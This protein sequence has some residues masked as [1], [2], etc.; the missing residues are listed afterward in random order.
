MRLRLLS[1]STIL[2]FMEAKRSL[3]QRL[4]AGEAVICAEGYLFELEKRGWLQAGPFV[5]TVVL[6]APEK[7]LELHR[8]FVHAGSDV[9]EA[10][11]YYAHRDKLRV[12]EREAD[13]ER[14]NLEALSLAKV[15]A[16]ETNTLLAGNICNSNIYT[17]EAEQLNLIREMVTEQ[18]QWALDAGV[19]F[20]VGETYNCYQEALV[21][22]QV[23]KEA[24]L[25][26]VITLAINSSGQ[27]IDGFAPDDACQ[28]LAEA[29]AD[30][31]GLN[32]L[33]GP[34]TM[35]PLLAEIKE[36]CPQTHLAA[37]PV[38]YRTTA[39]QPTFQSLTDPGNPK[40]QQRV[41]P[42]E[43]DPLYCARS[44]I[45]QFGADA[46]RMGYRYLGVCCG[47][48]ADHIRA[49]ATGIGREVPASTYQPDLSKHSYLGDVNPKNK[50]Y[51]ADM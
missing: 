48:R 46:Y 17:G 35:L 31:V 19:D 18:A 5:P 34:G 37:L 14:L 50:Q 13:I 23:I 47:A 3:L 45:T 38:P 29:G 8:E 28:R 26:A 51:V 22:L 33:R 16:E 11:T 15:V 43:L 1:R 49:L 30:V 32:C 41:F 20:I 27:T 42:T 7:V 44:E 21:G 36:R 9:V 6:E 40:P 39:S 25:P 10:L 4:E 24:G 2:C 12:I